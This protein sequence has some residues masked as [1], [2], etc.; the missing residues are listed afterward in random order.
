[1]KLLYPAGQENEQPHRSGRVL[2]RVN[3]KKD[4][5]EW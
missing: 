4:P 3:N 5:F 2:R 1:M